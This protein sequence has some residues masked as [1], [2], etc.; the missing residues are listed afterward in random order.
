MY[1]LVY[2]QEILKLY[3]TIDQHYSIV[4]S[5]VDAFLNAPFHGTNSI[6]KQKGQI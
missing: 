4:E 5:S 2:S 3:L 1:V 6:K